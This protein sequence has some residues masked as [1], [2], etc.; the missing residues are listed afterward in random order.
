MDP[1]G[2]GGGRDAAWYR[3][4][5]YLERF[6]AVE[7]RASALVVASAVLGV[8]LATILGL[9]LDHPVAHVVSEVAI[10]GFFLLV[11]LELRREFASGVLSGTTLGVALAA[12]AAGMALPA[13]I[14]VLRA[15][16][17][18]RDGW[19]AVVATDIALAAAITTI[20]GFRRPLR[21][22]LLTVAVLDD[23]G[24]LLALATTVKEPAPAWVAAAIAVVAAYAWAIRRF[25]L[26][27]T[28]VIVA[29][30]LV[31]AAMLRAGLH[32]SLGAFAVGFTAPNFDPGNPSVAERVEERVHP[33]VAGLLM[34]AFVFL[35]TLVPLEVPA[36]TSGS[37]I[38]WTVVAIV[39]GKVVGIGGV[40]ALVRRRTGI[41]AL[42]AVAVGCAA[43]AALTVALIGVDA[44]LDGTP[45]ARGVSLGV[46]AATA[47][48]CVLGVATGRAARR[49]GGGVD[50]P[51]DA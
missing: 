1:R 7:T 21:A 8:A 38:G 32:P 18:A 44:T 27:E 5:A 42:E 4:A 33:W 22:M 34:P 49:R 17:A 3:P 24:G 20:G 16:T 25:D 30:A 23:L 41:T 14:F 26:G 43:A 28:T 36:G 37:L 51:V 13:A 40:L 2:A 31:V 12:A 11:G 10:A 29:T 19:V 39:C 48:A 9:R 6:V 46:L 50:A 35:H 45:Y 47:V 15:P